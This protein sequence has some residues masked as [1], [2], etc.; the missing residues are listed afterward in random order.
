MALGN[1]NQ[2]N[3][4]T[5]TTSRRSSPTAAAGWSATS[6]RLLWAPPGT[7]TGCRSYK[8]P[9]CPNSE[10]FRF[11]HSLEKNAPAFSPSGTGVP[12]CHDVRASALAPPLFERQA[13][14]I[15]DPL[16]NEGGGASKKTRA[17]RQ[18]GTPVLLIQE[19]G[20]REKVASRYRK[21]TSPELSHK[22]KSAHA[23]PSRAL[24]NTG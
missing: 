16:Q 1:S 9:G 20:A 23:G 14:K 24:S 6:W 8:R 18:A 10:R 11:N 13:E 19:Q 3:A 4:H 7:A 17:A 15:V 2:C 22:A 5:L 21:G 12:A